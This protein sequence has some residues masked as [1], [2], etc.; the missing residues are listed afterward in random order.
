MGGGLEVTLGGTPMDHSI[1]FMGKL[2]SF[3]VSV[4][5]VDYIKERESLGANIYIF[6]TPNPV[7]CL[8]QL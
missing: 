8:P 3:Q 5:C 1:A 2:L 7:Q 4:N 6:L